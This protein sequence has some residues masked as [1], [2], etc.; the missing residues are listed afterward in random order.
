MSI[1]YF[2][3]FYIKQTISSNT[4]IS[5]IEFV[6][7]SDLE[8]IEMK[9]R[10]NPFVIECNNLIKLA[11]ATDGMENPKPNKLPTKHK[12]LPKCRRFTDDIRENLQAIQNDESIPMEVKILICS[13]ITM[14]PENYATFISNLRDKIQ[15][16]NIN[17][18]RNQ[19]K[20]KCN[21]NKQDEV[22]EKA[23]IFSE[24]VSQD[25]SKQ[26]F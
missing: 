7:D 12:N 5:K 23:Q 3:Y 25:E 18:S 2:I 15:P 9:K 14:S 1:C 21:K 10:W 26:N 11:N 24:K 13:A 8:R 22:E 17:E 19:N 16:K 4:K 6:S 20:V